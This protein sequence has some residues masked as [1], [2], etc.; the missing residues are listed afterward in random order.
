MDVPVNNL[1]SQFTAAL[2]G[3]TMIQGAHA[4]EILRGGILSVPRGQVEAAKAL[5]MRPWL[6]FR[7]VVLP[8][9]IRV[10]LPA[11][12]TEL[13]SLFKN[14]SLA[15]VIGYTELLGAATLI[16]DRNYQTIPLLLVACVWYILLTSIAMIGQS[17]LETKFGRG[18][19]R[20]DL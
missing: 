10:T 3:L 16:Y 19:S 8:P 4:G 5:G 18:F 1:V 17:R 7:R 15:S 2:I 6:T 9:T 12:A 11:L 14:T 20:T 13:I